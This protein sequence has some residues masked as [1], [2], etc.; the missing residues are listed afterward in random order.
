LKLS[1]SINF[2]LPTTELSFYFSVCISVFH[3]SQ[4]VSLKKGR[5]VRERESRDRERGERERRTERVVLYYFQAF[6][7][8][9]VLCND[10]DR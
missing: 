2:W 7:L 8:V 3:K 5:S 1:L 9:R 6:L 4:F 10:S